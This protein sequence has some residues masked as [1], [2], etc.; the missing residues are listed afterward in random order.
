MIFFTFR[1]GPQLSTVSDSSLH[2]IRSVR[3]STSQKC[4]R[5]T[6]PPPYAPSLLSSS[7]SHSSASSHSLSSSSSPT[8][9]PHIYIP[10]LPPPTP[11]SMSTSQTYPDPSTTASWNNTGLSPPIPG[12]EANQT[13]KSAP[14]VLGIRIF[15]TLG[16]RRIPLSSS[17]AP[18]TGS[19]ATS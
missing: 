6:P 11:S 1:N 3:P 10:K 9:H 2:S 16:T 7:L 4:L 15:S 12:W 8:T 5:R 19:R 17:T 18:S 14:P 13:I